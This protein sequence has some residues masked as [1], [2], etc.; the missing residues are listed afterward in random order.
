M[1][2]YGKLVWAITR[3][4]G[5]VDSDAS[6]VVQTAWMR[7]VEHID[8]LDHPERVGAWLATTTRNECLRSIA[9]RKR[10][11][12]IG[13]PN[14]L[15]DMGGCEQP[16]DEALLAAERAQR[17]QAARLKHADRLPQALQHVVAHRLGK[18]P[19]RGVPA[20]RLASLGS[21]HVSHRS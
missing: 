9:A 6:D 7:L 15:E 20:G 11:V 12:L 21:G 18:E 5:L 10:I 17:G 1:A 19:A 16:V 8:Q 13:E 14:R 2:Q 3:D 4:F